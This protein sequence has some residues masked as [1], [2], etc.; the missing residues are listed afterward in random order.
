M[1]CDFNEHLT[2]I[3][4]HTHT[5]DYSVS[6]TTLDDVFIHFANE[7]SEEAGLGNGTHPLVNN[8]STEAGT[9]LP[10]LVPVDGN[11]PVRYRELVQDDSTATGI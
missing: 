6:Q 8:G 1:S 11:H 9:T 2:V 4:T 7:Q 10:D 3:N 5:Q